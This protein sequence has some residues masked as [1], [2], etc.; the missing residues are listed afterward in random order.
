MEK[1]ENENNDKTNF[2]EESIQLME[3]I[4]YSL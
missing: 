4:L 2:P 3:S 1:K